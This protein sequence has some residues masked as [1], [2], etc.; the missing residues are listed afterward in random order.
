MIICAADGGGSNKTHDQFYGSYCYEYDYGHQG[1][2]FGIERRIQ[3][4]DLHTTN[5]AEYQILIELLERLYELKPKEDILINSDSQLVVNQ[6]SGV[7]QT[8]A[9]N[10]I[11]FRDKA[12][13]LIQKIQN[14]YQVCLILEWKGRAN[15]VEKLG[16]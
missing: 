1:M 4:P 11:P 5:E 16:H 3:F 14:E 7:F 10:L 6:I 2:V 12:R 9:V 13:E 8:G 15:S